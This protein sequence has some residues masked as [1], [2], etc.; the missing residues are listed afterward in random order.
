[1]SKKGIFEEIYKLV[2]KI[3]KGKVSTYGDLAKALGFVDS[4]VVGWALHGNKNPKVPCHRVVNKNGDLA[5]GYVFGG[6]QKQKERLTEEGISFKN[7]KTVDL[8]NCRV[9]PN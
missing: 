2:V 8:E 5:K 3:P 4:R 7:N 1:M 6:W 9:V